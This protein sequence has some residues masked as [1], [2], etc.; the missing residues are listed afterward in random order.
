MILFELSKL[1]INVKRT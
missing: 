1:G